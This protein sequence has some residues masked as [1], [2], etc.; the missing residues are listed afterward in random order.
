[1]SAIAK[2]RL[3]LLPVLVVAFLLGLVW[4]GAVPAAGQGG[5]LQVSITANPINPEVNEPTTLTAR[6]A[7]PPSSETPAYDWQMDFGGGEWY[8]LGSN[9]TFSYGNG[10]SE[11]LGFRLRVRYATGES[12]TSD[13]ITVTWGDPA[14][15]PIPTATPTPTEEPTPEPTET[16][17]PTATSTP[18]PTATP[19]PTEEPTPEPTE[20]P[21]PTATSTPTPTH[22]P[23]PTSIPTATSTPEPAE[24][25]T[26]TPTSTATSTPTPEP[27]EEPT[28]EPTPES[29]PTPTSIPTATSTPEPA[30]EQTPEPT[31]TPELASTSTPETIEE[32]ASTSTPETI[33]EPASTSTPISTPEP[34]PEPNRAPTVNTQNRS[35]AR[36]TDRGNAPRGIIVNKPFYGIFSDPDGDNLT[37]TVSL[38][39]GREQ[40][41]DILQIRNMGNSDEQAAGSGYPIEQLLWL[42]F[43]AESESDWKSLSPPLEDRPVVKVTLTATDPGGLWASVSGDFLVLWDSYPEVVSVESDGEVIELTFDWEVEDDPAPGPVQF[44]VNVV[45]GTVLRRQSV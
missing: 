33:E 34:T 29:T 7:N 39:Q 16:P 2:Y 21:T 17:T 9:S 27:A 23:T 10:K 36:F 41:V 22:T 30:E 8:S 44:T 43:R 4:A 28:P 15:T 3:V 40:L 6:I 18:T 26:P 24:T 32:P 1:M 38:S 13:P 31:S 37:Y 19:T 20:T 12:A 42:F 35:Y 25:P 11:T 14:P 5:G 45:N